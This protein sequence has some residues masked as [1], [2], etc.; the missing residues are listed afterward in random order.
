MADVSKRCPFCGSLDTEKQ[1]DFGTSL[2]VA[3][4]YCRQ[5]RSSFEAIKWG[6]PAAAADV[7]DFLTKHHD[8]TE[9]KDCHG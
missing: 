9:R 1:S 2:M 5:C 6:D 7:P 3:L 4:L 8:Q